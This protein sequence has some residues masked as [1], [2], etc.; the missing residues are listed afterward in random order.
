MV[1]LAVVAQLFSQIKQ[2]AFLKRYLFDKHKFISIPL[3]NFFFVN[4]TEVKPGESAWIMDWSVRASNKNNLLF[5]TMN[6][7][8]VEGWL[9]NDNISG[10]MHLVTTVPDFLDST[11]VEFRSPNQPGLYFSNATSH[12]AK[13][14]FGTKSSIKLKR[15]KAG[16]QITGD[17]YMT[18]VNPDTDQRM[19]FN[20]RPITEFSLQQFHAYNK[21]VDKKREADKQAMVKDLV[22]MIKMRDS[23]DDI[24]SKKYKDSIKAHPYMGPFRFWISD[25]DKVGY[26]RTT[27]RITQDSVEIKSG[28]YDFIYFA[29]NYSKDKVVYREK[30]DSQRVADL[31]TLSETITAS[32]LK[33]SYW[34]TCVIDGLIL[35]FQ[36]EWEG[37]VKQV[38]VD[39]YYKD[40]IALITDF[41]DKIVP[42]KY[43]IKYNKG[44]L[45]EMMKGCKL[46]IGD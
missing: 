29:K 27:Y 26:S 17:I 22:D 20:N 45:E 33:D 12:D 30:L 8:D 13:T 5:I 40:K 10:S 4:H 2:T 39:N 32:N 41:V 18:S 38:N 3:T 46:L 1:F 7:T 35:V 9:G 24:V 14:S 28:P 36:F 43:K 25:L 15:T 37:K 21:K 34:N 31:K 42:E 11:T 23:I 44:F 19:N 16:L 6:P